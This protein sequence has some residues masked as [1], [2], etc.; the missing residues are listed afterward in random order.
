MSSQIKEIPIIDFFEDIL[1][2][3][4]LSAIQKVTLKAIRAEPLEET[5]FIPA[6]HPYQKQE[7]FANE[8]EMFKFFTGKPDYKPCHYS[9]AS[10]LFGRRGG[11]STTVGAGLA[12][13]YGTQFDYTPYLG[14]SPHATIPIISATK[15]QAGEVFAAIKNFFLRSP[16]LFQKFLD[17]K[18]ERI[19]AEYSEEDVGKTA[20]ITGGEIKLNNKVVIKVMAADIGKIR[21]MAVPFA[22]LDENC[23]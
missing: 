20:K 3:Y 9:D 5:Q 8:V 16:W 7:G 15:E 17:G 6:A 4:N 14:T 1:G 13:Y 2:I 23:F 21:G 19:Q 12:I 18:V 22:I 11:K 10:L